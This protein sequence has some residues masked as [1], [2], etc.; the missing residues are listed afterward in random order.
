MFN[1]TRPQD[2]ELHWKSFQMAKRLIED[3]LH[4]N[5]LHIRHVLIER[6]ML[7]QEFRNESRNCSFTATHKN[8]L[9]NLFDLSVCRYSDVMK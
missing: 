1:K 5:K 6:V 9:L 2:F 4:K 7:Q 8:I 3:R